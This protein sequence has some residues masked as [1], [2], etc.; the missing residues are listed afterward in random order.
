M[1]SDKKFLSKDLLH[2]AGELLSS[3]ED[4]DRVDRGLVLSIIEAIPLPDDIQKPPREIATT[5][6]LDA[7]LGTLVFK[8][9]NR[10]DDLQGLL[11][12]VRAGVADSII[13]KRD[14]VSRSTPQHIIEAKL[15]YDSNY[16]KMK[17]RVDRMKR[18]VELLE[19]LKWM[20]V[21]RGEMMQEIYRKEY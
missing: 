14:R 9:S 15:A 1:S 11:D 18:F 5:G 10:L 19:A 13:E 6:E 16:T 7:T 21:R 20:C 8:Y 17:A 12:E 4:V 2:S 3:F